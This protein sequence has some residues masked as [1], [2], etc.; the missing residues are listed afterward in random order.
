MFDL[1]ARQLITSA[2][3]PEGDI[4]DSKEVIYSETPIPGRNFQP[5]SPG[6]NGNRKVSF[7]LPILSRTVLVGEVALIKQ[8]DALRNQS[9][10]LYGL[11]SGGQFKSNPKV[12][13]YWGIGS[14]PQV[15]YVAK[16]EMAHRS[17]MVNQ[18]GLPTY[19]MVDIELWLDET[20]PLYAAE[21]TFRGVAGIFGSI[22]AP[23]QIGR[24]L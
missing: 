13:Y 4:R 3:I 22:Q 17:D 19:T 10:G 14:V 21:E 20:D 5:I 9:R 1:A 12:L 2:T 16:C 23:A 24:F 7:K 18:A 11:T 8:F 6:G 15:W